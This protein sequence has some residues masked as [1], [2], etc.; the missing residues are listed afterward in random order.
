MVDN[1]NDIMEGSYNLIVTAF[2]GK[3]SAQAKV[4]INCKNITRSSLRFQRFK[5]FTKVKENSNVAK[6]LIRLTVI[7]DEKNDHLHFRILNTNSNMFK[8]L[9][10]SGLIRT[11]DIPF[12]REKK[13][14]YLL[15]VEVKS[16]SNSNR[17]DHCQVEVLVEDENDN[18][19]L[20]VNLPYYFAVNSHSS[21]LDDPIGKVQAIDLDV[22]QNGLVNFSIL[23]GDDKNLFRIDSEKGYIYLAR[24]FESFDQMDFNLVIE[25]SEGGN[26]N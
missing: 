11:T 22:G 3:F 13:S 1:P 15:I 21:Q 9:P 18:I 17:V 8:I 4:S 7:G 16:L 26:F 12:D 25:A 10:S 2:D 23:S 20:F 6:N 5:Y 24:K 19:P 14:H